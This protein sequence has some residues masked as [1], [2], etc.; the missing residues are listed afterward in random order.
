MYIVKIKTELNTI[1]FEIESIEMLGDLTEKYQ[2]YIE[3]RVN[4]KTEKSKKLV[5]KKKRNERK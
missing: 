2:D 1:E 5:Y 3:I 4:K